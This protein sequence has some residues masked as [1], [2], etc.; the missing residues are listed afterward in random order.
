ME[1][2]L[3]KTGKFALN[4]GVLTGVIGVIF[5]IM[6]FAMNMHYDQTVGIQ[7]TNTLILAGGIVIGILQFK[8]AAGGFLT[9][10]EALKVGAG[11]AL[12]PAPL[13]I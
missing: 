11:V 6:L 3:P 4:Y 12:N 8:K 7:V 5:G 13:N 10:S 2:N 9:I 1:E